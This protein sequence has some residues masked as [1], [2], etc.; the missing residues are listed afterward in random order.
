MDFDL[1]NHVVDAID[2]ETFILCC[3][4]DEGKQI[5]FGFLKQIGLIDTDIV[6]IEFNGLGARIRARGYLYRP[7]DEYAWLSDQQ[8]GTKE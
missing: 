1:F 8:G 4:E 7:G 2:V 6:F 3:D 5:M